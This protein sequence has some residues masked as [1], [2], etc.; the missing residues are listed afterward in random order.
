MYACIYACLYACMYLYINI[1]IYMYAFMYVCMHACMYVCIYVCIYTSTSTCKCTCTSISISI[2]ISIYICHLGLEVV[3][4]ERSALL[5][6]LGELVAVHVQF[7]ER[8]KRLSMPVVVLERLPV[9]AQRIIVPLRLFVVFGKL[10]TNIRRNLSL[11]APQL[12]SLAAHAPQDA[13]LHG[14]CVEQALPTDSQT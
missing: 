3:L 5:T 11:F 14:V 6:C 10:R 8:D 12:R 2:S 13:A 1:Y 7:G 4:E 9:E